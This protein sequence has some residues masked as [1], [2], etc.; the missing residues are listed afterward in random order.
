MKQRFTVAACQLFDVQDDL[1]QTLEEI[2][3]YATQATD[4]GAT[5]VC[6]PENYLQGYTVDERQARRRAIDLSSVQ[7][8]EILKQLKPLRPTL[9][10][11]LIEKVEESLYITA[12][13]VQRG[14]LLGHYRKN[15]LTAGERLYAAGTETPVFEVDGL[16]FGI[17]I[18]Y[19]TQC[20]QRAAAVANQGAALVV[21]PCYNMLHPENA[22]TWK[23]KHNAIRAERARETGL[24][25]LSSDVT[26]ERDGQISYGPTAV[27]DPG[28]DVV[29]Q[30]PL[31]EEGLLVQEILV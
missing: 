15:R 8:A 16:R 10:I 4:E 3:E 29:A 23:E 12:V 22:E 27:I 6:F 20:S 7:F 24:W 28:G 11:G 25:L 18:C 26:G 2:I 5:L 19:D 31:L 17:N 1:E 21:C 9:V 13:V 30:V 14:K